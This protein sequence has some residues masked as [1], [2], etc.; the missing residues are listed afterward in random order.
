MQSFLWKSQLEKNRLFPLIPTNSVYLT[1]RMPVNRRRSIRSTG[2]RHAKSNKND[3]M[4]SGTA[5]REE[6]QRGD[7]GDWVQKMGL[8][9]NWHGIQ[10]GTANREN[11]G[12]MWPGSSIKKAMAPCT[13]SYRGLA[14]PNAETASCV[15]G[16]PAGGVAA[17][18]STRNGHRVF[19]VE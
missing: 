11:S 18:S 16:M 4:T 5:W 7:P 13:L 3:L 2:R 19:T 6:Q 14:L 17:N 15:L 10:W 12:S 9:D 8:C 1:L